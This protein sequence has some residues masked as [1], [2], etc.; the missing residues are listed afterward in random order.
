MKVMQDIIQYLIDLLK[1]FP[2]WLQMLLL[3]ILI[4]IYYI[5]RWIKGGRK[6]KLMIMLLIKKTVKSLS[7]KNLEY[8]DL[9]LSIEVYKNKLTTLNLGD[10]DKTD[11][12]KVFFISQ[13]N[14]V[15]DNILYFIKEKNYNNWK[16]DCFM[17]GLVNLMKKINEEAENNVLKT[18]SHMY[19]DKDYLAIYNTVL[20]DEGGFGLYSQNDMNNILMYIEKLSK[21]AIFDSNY[22]KLS[23]YM[24]ILDVTL[25]SSVLKAEENFRGFNGNFEKHFK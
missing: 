10:K 13:L 1:Q 16:E 9:F 7:K 15:R 23:W 18:L 11:V 3:P 21:S 14:S 12:F 17:L 6:S 25:Q 22:E 4:G 24:D 2:A 8:H 19:A 20:L 5:L